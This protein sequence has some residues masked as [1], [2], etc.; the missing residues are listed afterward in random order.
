MHL[1]RSQLSMGALPRLRAVLPRHGVHSPET[2]PSGPRG[3]SAAA[4]AAGG[5][6]GSRAEQSDDR[7]AVAA[8]SGNVEGRH[9]KRVPFRVRVRPRLEEQV[10]RGEV[11]GV[12]G[13]VDGC[14]ARRVGHVLEQRAAPAWEEG[15]GAKLHGTVGGAVYAPQAR[16]QL[17][18]RVINVGS[19]G[20][21][22]AQRLH[23]PDCREGER[24]SRL[25]VVSRLDQFKS[26]RSAAPKTSR[27]TSWHRQRLPAKLALQ[28][29]Q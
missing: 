8:Q 9:A 21:R 1:T 4:R 10:D 28:M 26:A 16:G 11:S 3:G 2:R 17:G 15:E 6:R 24:G 13:A 25:A 12:G 29:G 5:R 20:Q 19:G 27:R 23:V 7:L 14:A 18:L 22:L